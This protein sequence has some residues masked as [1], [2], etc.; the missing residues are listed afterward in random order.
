MSDTSF[1]GGATAGIFYPG[2]TVDALEVDLGNGGNQLV[3]NGNPAVSGDGSGVSVSTGNGGD[4][5]SVNRTSAPLSLFMGDGAFQTV[6]IGSKNASLDNI[7]DV[8]VYAGGVTQAFVSD[9]AATT[10]QGFAIS[11]VNGNTEDIARYD[12]ANDSPVT[13]NT[14]TFHFTT[15]GQVDL[16]AGK[17]GDEVSVRGTPSNTTTIITGGAGKDD[18]TIEADAIA[19]SVL[20]PLD[21]YGNASQGDSALIYGEDS[22]TPAQ[23]YIFQATASKPFSQPNVLDQQRVLIGGDAPITMRGVATLTT[24]TASVGSFVSIQGVPAG[25]SLNVFDFYDDRVVFGNALSSPIGYMADIRGTVSIMD[26]GEPESVT[27]DDSLDSTGRHVYLEPATDSRGDVIAGMSPGNIYL[28]LGATSTVNL[29]GGLGNDT[30]SMLG[31]GFGANFSVDGGRGT[32]TLDYSGASG[33]AGPNGV[34]VNLQTGE[35]SGLVNGISRIQNVNGSP[36]DDILVGNGG[37]FLQGGAGRDLLIAGATASNLNGGAD[38][39]LLIGG[40]TAYDTDAA[41]LEAVLAAWAVNLDTSLLDGQVTSNGGGNTLLG[42]GGTDFFFVGINDINTT[43]RKKDE[44]V[45]YV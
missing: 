9:A 2:L 7:G 38:E 8:N 6:A 36:L 19:P 17:G 26:N 12:P 37:N 18:V 13:L 27:L 33:L 45:V 35:A 22:L 30:F 32:N 1:T 31:T 14:F 24:A 39:D 41:E 43:D 4:A 16:T 34:Y 28:A 11:S 5:V 44:T 40:T 23:S 25:E 3:V 42:Q 10:G 29:I 21:F 20:G 15:P